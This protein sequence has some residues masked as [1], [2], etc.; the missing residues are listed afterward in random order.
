MRVA[1]RPRSLRR[2]LPGGPVPPGSALPRATNVPLEGRR[3]ARDTRRK[4]AESPT[5]AEVRREST[6]N[7]LEDVGSH[8]PVRRISH[9]GNWPVDCAVGG[10]Q[11]ADVIDRVPQAS[12]I[13]WVARGRRDL[14]EPRLARSGLRGNVRGDLNIDQF[15]MMATAGRRITPH[16]EGLLSLAYFDLSTDLEVRVVE[17]RLRASRWQAKTKN[18]LWHRG[19]LR[20]YYLERLG[21]ASHLRRIQRH[22]AGTCHSGLLSLRLLR[23]S[24]PLRATEQESDSSTAYPR[25]DRLS[26]RSART[27]ARD[28]SQSWSGRFQKRGFGSPRR[29]LLEPEGEPKKR[30]VARR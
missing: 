23:L 20:E 5:Q 2:L 12:R 14:H 25:A 30:A 29:T 4:S 17:Q 7:P 11:G 18:E 15:T 27:S 8:E 6:T 22:G 1:S 13:E 28:L 24:T 16:V 9:H 21:R 10:A 26:S 3:N 19:G